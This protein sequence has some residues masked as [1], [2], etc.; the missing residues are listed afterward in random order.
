ML[1]WYCDC[2][3][4]A[5]FAYRSSVSVLYSTAKLLMKVW[6]KGRLPL[7]EVTARD[8]GVDAQCLTQCGLL[9]QHVR[10]KR[11]STFQQRIIKS[12]CSVGQPHQTC[13]MKRAGL[14]RAASLELLSCTGPA[15]D[16]QVIADP[17]AVRIWLPSIRHII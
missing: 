13:P 3:H 7:V 16:P 15:G 12:L 9:A 5:L 6:Q 1:T 17:N 10:K 11:I 4:F 14:R 2:Y 8:L